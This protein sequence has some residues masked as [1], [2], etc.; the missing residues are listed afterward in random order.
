MTLY[1][2]QLKNMKDGQACRAGIENT[3]RSNNNLVRLSAGFNT[4]TKQNT[5][6]S[7]I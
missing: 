4:K 7:Y 5:Q 2:K 3:H 1:H 6:Q